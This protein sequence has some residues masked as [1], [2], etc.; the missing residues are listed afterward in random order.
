VHA[1]AHRKNL[2][3]RKKKPPCLRAEEFLKPDHLAAKVSVSW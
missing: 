3:N 1:P 2:N